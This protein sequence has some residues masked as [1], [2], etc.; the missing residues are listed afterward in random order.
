MILNVNIQMIIKSL[1]S[2]ELEE[3]RAIVILQITKGNIVETY[4]SSF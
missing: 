4:L 3:S 1:T 2:F